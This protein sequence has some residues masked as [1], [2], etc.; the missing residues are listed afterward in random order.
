MTRDS[1]ATPTMGGV[2][3]KNDSGDDDNVL[4]LAFGRGRGK[5]KKKNKAKKGRGR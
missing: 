5:K 3:D 4:P 1:P 2:V